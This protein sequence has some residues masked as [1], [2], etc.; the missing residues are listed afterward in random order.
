MP[1][2]KSFIYRKSRYI[3]ILE[4]LFIIWGIIVY[5]F[6]PWKIGP[7]KFIAFSKILSIF[8]LNAKISILI[9]S[10]L[11][12]IFIL[13]LI[14]LSF[15][16]G[17]SIIRI[18]KIEL[19]TGQKTVTYCGLGL[20][21]LSFLMFFLG[22]TGL[23]FSKVITIILVFLFAS[24]SIYNIDLI[25]D[26][27]LISNVLRPIKNISIIEAII[28]FFILIFLCLGFLGAAS[29]EIFY[30]SL[31]YHLSLPNL[32]LLEHKI[33]STP[34]NLFSGIPFLT[35]ML[36]GLGL[37]MS[38]V[39]AAKL[40]HYLFG[41]L[42]L[43]VIWS[44]TSHGFS[45]KTVLLA[46]FIFCSTPIVIWEFM[47]AAVELSWTYFTLLAVLHI[48]NLF[49]ASE[50]KSINNN[51]IMS[52]IFSGFA[53]STKYPAWLIFPV[54]VL[55]I[56]FIGI[57]KQ[58]VFTGRI[59]QIILFTIVTS[60]LVFPW[61]AKNTFFYK[62]PV[63]P[64]LNDYIAG[65]SNDDPDW[66]MLGAEARGE[67]II[68]KLSSFQG[69]KNYIKY[70]WNITM[71][72]I[73]NH[74]FIGAVFLFFL[75]WL[76]Y[77]GIKSQKYKYLL[78]FFIGFY[79]ILSITTIYI[80]FFIPVL[81]LLSILL[82][83][84]IC[85]FSPGYLKIFAFVFIILLSGYNFCYTYNIWF[86]T[87]SWM[88]FTGQKSRDVYLSEAHKTYP[89][90]YYQTAVYINK[91]LPEDSKILI[92]GDERGLYY[93]RK[94]NAS[95][96]FNKQHFLKIL[97]K[98]DNSGS[99]YNNLKEEGFTHILFNMMEIYRLVPTHKSIKMLYTGLDNNK[100]SILNEFWSKYIQV[101]HIESNDS[102]AGDRRFVILYKLLPLQEAEQPHNI[103]KNHFLSILD[104]VKKSE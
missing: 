45:K 41:I 3:F 19:K 27:S 10:I 59:R 18:C 35:E 40:I 11:P 7:Q 50:E 57:K 75:P 56:Y 24:L 92:V 100:V 96:V 43:S 9:K 30:D 63:Y 90:P 86:Q 71:N 38:G 103:P 37:S 61:I 42:V 2:I 8:V 97:E 22:M 46:S 16:I 77:P 93:Q 70:P 12:L 4:T 94:Y 62:N 13:F 65:S 74:D 47:E 21:F 84:I 52:G 101:V 104:Q 39:E 81:A 82:S 76:L 53:M 54:L 51:L 99:F 64:F 33:I 80:R 72:G 5:A 20:G 67:N 49:D 58:M 14:I 17:R 91:N 78:C 6:Y 15:L 87:D 79:I 85:E 98:S 68:T 36:Y 73:S 1:K 28:A 66:R 32:Y 102:S 26:K 31:I 25:R 69:V 29:P 83:V 88:V 23:W 89:S 48:L 34:Q 60:V 55:L 95:S 44:F